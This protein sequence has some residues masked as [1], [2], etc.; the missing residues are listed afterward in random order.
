MFARLVREG[1]KRIVNRCVSMPEMVPAGTTAAAS[2]SLCLS[3]VG[4]TSAYKGSPLGR[5]ASLTQNARTAAEAGPLALYHHFVSEGT[6]Q[7]DLDQGMT[8]YKLSSLFDAISKSEPGKAI[9]GFYIYGSVGCGKT[10]AMDI[11][12]AAVHVAMPHLKV[13][14]IH[15]NSF[16]E[17]VHSDLRQVQKQD[18]DPTVHADNP[19]RRRGNNTLQKPFN[20]GRV[21]DEN[22]MRRTGSAAAWVHVAKNGS[23]PTSIERLGQQLAQRIDVLCLDDVSITNLQNCVLLGPLIRALCERGV[24]L[25]ATSNK[26]PDELYEDGLDREVHLPPL[27]AAICDHCTV[28]RHSSGVDYRKLLS[29]AGS[30]PDVFKWRCKGTVESLEFVE[31]WWAALSGTKNQVPVPVGYGRIL[32]VMQS[33]CRACARFSFEDLCTYPPTA[34]GSADYAELCKH[35]HT[36]VVSSVPRLRPEARDAAR[37]WTLFLDSCYES[38]IRLILSTAAEDPEDL[39]NL[40]QD[41]EDTN[42]GQSLQE[43]SFAVARCTSRLHEMQSISYQKACRIRQEGGGKISLCNNTKCTE[44]HANCFA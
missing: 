43:A 12:A 39:L 10:M 15:L 34:L 14:R 37:R 9:G 40:A 28:L 2:K 26:A 4:A 23:V 32:P 18:S 29:A 31:S 13:C 44:L 20:L 3:H 21:S 17:I 42:D 22:G 19:S 30:D 25:I 7:M 24:V 16:L 8:V 6:L 11:F 36:L 27:A 41:G 1:S 38:H 33:S 5:L 35:F